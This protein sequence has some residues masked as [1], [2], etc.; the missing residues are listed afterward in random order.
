YPA[1]LFIT[2]DADTRVAPLH[3]RKMA[4]L[5]QASTGS[6]K[7]VM[8]RYYTSAG[9]AGGQPVSEQIEELA[10]TMSFL[11]WQLEGEI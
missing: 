1:I 4:A 9:H 6:G 2:G 11:L 8:I 3:A 10:E 5:M 7:P